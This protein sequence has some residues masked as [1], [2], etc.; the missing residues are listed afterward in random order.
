MSHGLH[1]NEP[2]RPKFSDDSQDCIATLHASQNR[3][4]I[5]CLKISLELAVVQWAQQARVME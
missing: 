4:T 2:M 5:A 3:G 1:V